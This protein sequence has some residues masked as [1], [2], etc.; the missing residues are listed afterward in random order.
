MDKIVEDYYNSC[1]ICMKNKSRTARPIGTLSKLGPARNPFAVMSID[2]VRGFGGIAE[3]VYAYLGRSIDE[4]SLRVNFEIPDHR[5][6]DQ[7]NQPSSEK[8]PYR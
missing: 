5:R 3:E 6:D 1:G 8:S 4:E 7:V 2:T